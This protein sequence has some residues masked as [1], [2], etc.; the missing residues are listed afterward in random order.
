MTPFNTL[1]LHWHV[2]RDAAGAG[3]FGVAG[4]FRPIT[5]ISNSRKPFRSL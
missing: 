1:A 2:F 3:L 5:A 4:R